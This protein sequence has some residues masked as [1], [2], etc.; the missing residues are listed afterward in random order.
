VKKKVDTELR[1][2]LGLTKDASVAAV[3][4]LPTPAPAAAARAKG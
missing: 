4:P 3:A 1:K 2:H